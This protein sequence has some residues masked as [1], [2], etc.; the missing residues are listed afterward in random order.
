MQ[1][2]GSQRA[3]GGTKPVH[4][5]LC[6]SSPTRKSGWLSRGLSRFPA[7]RGGVCYSHQP[8]G[9]PEDLQDEAKPQ[10]GRTVHVRREAFQ[11]RVCLL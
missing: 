6:M 8:G 1:D 7:R 10:R 9:C 5:A 4:C 2:K 11:G 3:G